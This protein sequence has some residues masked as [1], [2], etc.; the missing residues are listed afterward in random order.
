MKPVND[1][2]LPLPEAWK[3]FQEERFQVERYR[4]YPSPR[5][6]KGAREGENT[7]LVSFPP[8]SRGFVSRFLSPLNTVYAD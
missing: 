4:G 6:S 8:S 1:K 5:G 3:S 7:C 2:S